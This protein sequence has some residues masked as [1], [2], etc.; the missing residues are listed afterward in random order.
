[1][2]KCFSSSSRGHEIGSVPI[3]RTGWV[4]CDASAMLGRHRR[5]TSGLCDDALGIAQHADE[6][7]A[8]LLVV[9]RALLSRFMRPVE[10]GR[11]G[12]LLIVEMPEPIGPEASC[13]DNAAEPHNPTPPRKP[14]RSRSWHRPSGR[15]VH[16]V[17]ALLSRGGSISAMVQSRSLYRSGG[18]T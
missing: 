8:P 18:E 6:P 14:T 15:A 5:A 9:G 1:V 12:R 7:R 11:R 10:R 17:A 4:S 16:R 3:V 13:G 2:A